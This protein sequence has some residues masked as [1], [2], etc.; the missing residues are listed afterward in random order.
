M[1]K[2][3]GADRT[4]N[5]VAVLREWQGIE[6]QA[7]YDTSEIIENAKNPLVRLIMEIIRHDS[8]MHH[9]VQQFLIDSLTVEAPTVAREDLAEI[10]DRIERHDR[11]EKRT[12]ELAKDLFENA[13]TPIQKQLLD[14]LLKDEAKHDA[15]LMHLNELKKDMSRA[16]GA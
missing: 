12:I 15:L 14:Y 3:K 10:W 5:M 2:K 16:S 4:E 8:A 1:A 6:R 9:R 13:W 11:A 7:G